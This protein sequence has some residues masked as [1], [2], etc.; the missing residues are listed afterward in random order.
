MTKYMTDKEAH[1]FMKRK[2]QANQAEI[3]PSAKKKPKK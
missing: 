3:K 1:D 2:A